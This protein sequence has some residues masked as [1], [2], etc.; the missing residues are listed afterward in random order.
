MIESHGTTGAWMGADGKRELGD[1]LPVGLA[2][3]AANDVRADLTE[4][5]CTLI[6]S[7]LGDAGSSCDYESFMRV[8]CEHSPGSRCLRCSHLHLEGW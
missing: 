5:S 2:Q 4:E 8:V 3:A 1:V 7:R 6:F